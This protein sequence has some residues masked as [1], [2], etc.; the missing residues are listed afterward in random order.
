M[1]NILIAGD[2]FTYGHGC[3]DRV[4]YIDEATKQRIGHPDNL[5]PG[6]PSKH[7]WS[8]LLDSTLQKNFGNKYNIINVASPGFDNMSILMSIINNI[9]PETDLVIL[10]LSVAARIQIKNPYD[11]SAVSWLLAHAIY[12]M[13]PNS[14]QTINPQYIAARENYLKYLYTESIT[15]NIALSV[16]MAAYGLSTLYNTK[17]LWAVPKYEELDVNPAADALVQHKISSIVH[18]PW[19]DVFQ[20]TNDGDEAKFQEKLNEVYKLVLAADSHVSN[21]GHKLYF[22]RTIWPNIVATL[23]L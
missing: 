9:T 20:I 21:Y 16:L 8:S 12:P 6:V 7:A 14:E 3:S 22:E 4:S 18:Y 10:N 19:H 2:S 5:I 13:A 17:F 23:G 15:N 1:K 11:E